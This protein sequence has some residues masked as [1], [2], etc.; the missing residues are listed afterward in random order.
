MAVLET[1]RMQLRQFTMDDVQNLMQIM[2]DPIAMKYYPWVLDEI[3]TRE[4]IQR[5]LDR[6]SERGIGLWAAELKDNGEFVGQVG[7]VH[8]EIEGRKEVEIAYLFVSKHWGKGY[9]TEAAEACKEFAFR[10]LDLH[11][12]VIVIRPENISSRR[13]A[14][15]LGAVIEKEYEKNGLI[16]LVYVLNK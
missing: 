12:V 15:R 11:R 5:N 8:M 2:A 6:Y 9:A 3:G 16:H 1:K 7:L 13:V 14:E 4:W 10:H